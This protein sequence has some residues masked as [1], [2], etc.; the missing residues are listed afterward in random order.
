M[1]RSASS[2]S[3]APTP[4][5]APPS[6]ALVPSLLRMVELPSGLGWAEAPR[7]A[8]SLPQ[9]TPAGPTS[10]P[11]SML[12]AAR[13]PRVPSSSD[14]AFLPGTSVAQPSGVVAQPGQVQPHSLPR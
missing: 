11:V 10:A 4:L 5:P 2:L 7:E 13:S 14:R 12:L 6:P 1:A 8:L 3:T 9:S